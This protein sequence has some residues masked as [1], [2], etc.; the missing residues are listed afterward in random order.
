VGDGH[1]GHE[2]TGRA[3]AGELFV[4]FSAGIAEAPKR[5]PVREL[6]RA[7]DLALHRAKQEGRNWIA[8]DA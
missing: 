8:V 6:L 7:A 5:S 3:Q 2:N 4:T 1:P